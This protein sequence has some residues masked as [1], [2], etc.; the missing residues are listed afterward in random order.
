MSDMNQYIAFGGVFWKSPDGKTQ[1]I[2]HC[3]R[4]FELMHDGVKVMPTSTFER[5]TAYVWAE[6]PPF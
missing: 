1:I 6:F 4:V 2:R 5:L 3:D